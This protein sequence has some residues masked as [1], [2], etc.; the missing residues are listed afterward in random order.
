MLSSL[1]RLIEKGF[2]ASRSYL[3]YNKKEKGFSNSLK[4]FKDTKARGNT[5]RRIS[6][7]RYL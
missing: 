3:S 5:L 6:H 4:L 1:K 7:K 2:N